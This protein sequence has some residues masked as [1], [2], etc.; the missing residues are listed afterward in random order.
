MR[1][2]S[3]VPDAPLAWPIPVAGAI[4]AVWAVALTVITL[5]IVFTFGWI[6]TADPTSNYDTALKAATSLWLLA[7]GSPLSITSMTF[8]LTPLLLTVPVVF[9]LKIAV[10]WAIRSTRITNAAGMFGLIFA[11]AGTYSILALLMSLTVGPDI[12]VNASRTL[13]VTALWA[14]FA[15]LWAISDSPGVVVPVEPPVFDGPGQ[16]TQRIVKVRAPHDVLV[17]LWRDIPQPFRHGMLISVRTL[18]SQLTLAA[19]CAVGL[20]IWRS[21]EISS[22]VNTLADNSV[23]SLSVVLLTSLYVPTIIGW[24]AAVLYGPGLVIGEGSPYNFAEQQLGPFPVLPFLATI[25]ASLPAW[26]IVFVSISLAT[27]VLGSLKWIRQLQRATVQPRLGYFLMVL[28]SASVSSFFLVLIM[29]ALVSGALGAG[30]YLVV[31][32]VGFGVALAAA[33]WTLIGVST[34]LGIHRF[35]RN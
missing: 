11:T 4:A 31:G 16:R 7:H 14:V 15:S 18:S 3:D 29:S 28:L 35:V 32:P 23:D 8:G 12:R 17:D 19:A 6:A 5:M 25:P 34:S 26:S 21:N 10:R 9:V 27:A 20:I 24:I 30:R 13:L 33:G 1:R 2:R 22:I